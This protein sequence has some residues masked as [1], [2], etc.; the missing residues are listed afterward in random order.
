MLLFRHL[1]LGMK[2]KQWRVV[3]SQ[4]MMFSFKTRA[5]MIKALVFTVI[6]ISI[7]ILLLRNQDAYQVLAE[8]LPRH[9]RNVWIQTAMRT[10]IDGKQDIRPVAELCSRVKWTEG[11]ILHCPNSQGGVGNVRNKILGCLR[12]AIEMGGE[13]YNTYCHDVS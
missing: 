4:A 13:L 8:A 1:R 9:N 5:I 2:L 3:I 10:Q 6:L 12:Y 7:C 11:L